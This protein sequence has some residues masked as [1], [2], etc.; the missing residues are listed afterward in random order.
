[1]SIAA[2]SG[3][4]SDPERRFSDHRRH[5]MFMVDVMPALLVLY[6]RRR[7]P[8]SLSWD[9]PPPR[10][11]QRRSSGRIGGSASMPWF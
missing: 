4:T 11:V 3:R 9:L 6:I 2:L 10:A 5:G 8:E 7:M 1:M